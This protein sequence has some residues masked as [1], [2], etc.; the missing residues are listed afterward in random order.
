M[1]TSTISRILLSATFLASVTFGINAVAQAT[2]TKAAAPANGQQAGTQKAAA[3][4]KAV[5]SNPACQ[6]I[7]DECKKLGFIQGEWKTDN[8]LWKDC[9]DPVVHSGKP[10]RDGKSIEVPVSASDV[11]SCRGTVAQAKQ[12]QKAEQPKQ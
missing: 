8:G 1:N 11:Q 6:R 2:A 9:F 10:T 3:A 4:K 7:V 12:A 5:E